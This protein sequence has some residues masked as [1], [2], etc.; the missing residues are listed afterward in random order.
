MVKTLRQLFCW[1]SCMKVPIMSLSY[2]L[3]SSCSLRRIG[4]DLLNEVITRVRRVR[5]W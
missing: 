5:L 1:I 2:S 3:P 4:V